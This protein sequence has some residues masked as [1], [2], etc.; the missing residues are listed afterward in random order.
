MTYRN[1]I[2][3]NKED[4]KAL[5]YMF[6]RLLGMS[7][8]E[9]LG[10]IAGS[11]TIE[12][13]P[14]LMETFFGNLVVLGN[15][16][17]AQNS[18]VFGR[19]FRRHFSSSPDYYILKK[20][21]FPKTQDNTATTVEKIDAVKQ[22]ISVIGGTVF[23]YAEAYLRCPK[24]MWA[25]VDFGYWSTIERKTEPGIGLY[26]MFHWRGSDKLPERH[27]PW[28]DF[29]FSKSPDETRAERLLRSC[30]QKAKKKAL[31]KAPTPYRKI[32]TRFQ[33]P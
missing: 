4:R 10:H 31:K 2:D 26:V 30:F 27:L 33:I 17:C 15:W 21:A 5:H 18:E 3:L 23:L 9:G 25:T 7:K 14:R 8:R 11:P 1:D 24:G 22:K 19:R 12:A 13:I 28:A 6:N 16:V 29:H 20:K 32:I